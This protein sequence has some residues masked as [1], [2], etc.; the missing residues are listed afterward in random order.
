VKSLRAGGLL[1][2]TLIAL[3]WSAAAFAQKTTTDPTTTDQTT[4]TTTSTTTKAP[5][6]WA[7]T[8]TTRY[9]WRRATWFKLT[10]RRLSNLMRRESPQLH[11][12]RAEFHSLLA[13]R[14]W[15][16][17]AWRTKAADT[18]YRAHHPPH[19]A[20]WLCIHRWEGAWRDPNAPYYG[21]LQM[22]LAFQ[23]TYA[24]A[25]LRRKGTAD[26]WAPWEQMWVAERALRAGRGFYPW[27]LTARRCRLI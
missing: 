4:T 22:D 16:R 8:A 26:H 13:Y 5:D 10:A 17:Y 23:R 18:R 21:G 11:R 12:T 6:A 27:P 24:A 25:L 19:L 3:L 14:R 20:G 15:L 2:A 7:E 1:L 9:L